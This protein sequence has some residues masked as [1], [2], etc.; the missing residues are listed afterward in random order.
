MKSM[1]VVVVSLVS[2]VAFTI[3]RQE[4]PV[5]ALLTAADIEAVTGGKTGAPVPGDNMIA[6]SAANGQMRMC[7]WPVTAQTGQMTL[8]T[9]VLP[10]GTSATSL[11]KQSVGMMRQ[12]KYTIEE[13]DYGNA[14]CGAATPPASDK[15]APIL[16]TC[17]GGA[18]GKIFSL[19][20]MS[21]TKKLALDQ[22]KA[23]LDKA[24]SR[25]R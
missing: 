19:S 14:W 10:S 1:N 22:T 9:G 17:A 25:Q 16:T 12:A 7:M 3:T 15:Q 21:S 5:C 2:M 18:K 23:L 4:S 13:K 20:Y 6:S 24:I 11:A 8:S